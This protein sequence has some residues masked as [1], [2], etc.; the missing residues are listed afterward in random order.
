MGFE[1]F[2]SMS[3]TYN[4]STT[5]PTANLT[6]GCTDETNNLVV[7]CET[8]EPSVRKYD[9][10]SGVQSGV[11]M[12]TL[13]SPAAICMMG[14]S[15]IVAS[16]TVST[17]DFIEVT[18]G[19]RQNVSGGSTVTYTAKG[20]QS[21]ADASLKIAFIASSTSRTITKVDGTAFT[22]TQ[23]TFPIGA[24]FDVRTVILKSAG[25][26]LC[27][28][29][30]GKVIEI[31]STPNVIDSLVLDSGPRTGASVGQSSAYK[32]MEV[33]YMS[34][35]DNILL[36]ATNDMSL[37]AY[38]WSTKTLIWQIM[39]GRDSSNS[40]NFCLSNGASGV[41]VIGKGFSLQ[42]GTQSIAE[43]DMTCQTGI[44]R[45]QPLYLDTV[46]PVIASGIN[47]TNGKAWCLQ[48]NAQRIRFFSVTPRSTTTRT[49]TVQVSGLDVNARLIII[50]DTNQLAPMIIL[51]TY[52]KSPGNY[53]VPTGKNIIEIVEYGDGA[54]ATADV[55]TYTT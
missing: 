48:N 35:S 23:V 29:E 44:V 55:S 31:D 52:M 16:T 40:G 30:D 2:F 18:T 32:G 37:S 34:F 21:A 53:R 42:D 6:D 50:D 14:A 17:V 41:C 15:A 47:T 19:R 43:F 4:T 12:V 33:K 11:D 46:D 20:Q 1:G 39:A 26:W 25:R 8:T 3:I 10:T 36:V 9:L 38:D 22:A 7:V 28:T 27:G 49:V 5:P 13:A 45:D 54:T 51:D 24:N